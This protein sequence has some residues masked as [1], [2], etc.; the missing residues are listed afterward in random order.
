M[1][2]PV[3]V[4][5]LDKLKV[6]LEF[7]NAFELVPVAVKRFVEVVDPLINDELPPP[8]LPAGPWNPW[9]P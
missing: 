5:I 7:P 8:P 1:I 3:I 4:S 9:V 6:K 2:A